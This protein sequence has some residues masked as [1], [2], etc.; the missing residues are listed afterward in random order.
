MMTS[1]LFLVG[2]FSRLRQELGKS[3]CLTVGD[4]IGKFEK[5]LSDFKLADHDLSTS[6]PRP[7]RLD[8]GRESNLH[9]LD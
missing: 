3:L 9:R 7:R 4:I 6:N 8:N 1:R 2:F 5:Y